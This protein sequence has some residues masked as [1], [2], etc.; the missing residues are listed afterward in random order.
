MPRSPRNAE[1]GAFLR[2]RRAERAPED[3]SL[4]ITGDDRR[5]PGL[6]RQ[7]VAELAS[8]S[9][10]YYTRIEQGRMTAS[11]PV[12]ANLAQALRLSPDEWTYMLKLAVDRPCHHTDADGEPMRVDATV[13]RLLNDLGRTPAFVIGPHTEVLAWNTL[14]TRVFLDFGQVPAP[15]RIF[16]RLLFTDPSLRALYA[17][18]AEVAHLAIDQLRMHTVHDLDDPALHALVEELSA[19]SPEFT[20]WWEARQVNIRTTGTKLLHHPVVGDLELDWSTL[21]CAAS[22]DQQVVA[23]T[24]EPGSATS[25]ALRELI[26]AP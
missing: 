21:T 11:L 15:Q 18:W 13:Q 14:A 4:S 16:V 20:A 9:M 3:V 22:P 10:D 1:L 26:T 7:E 5:V 23:W 17:D 24:A 8:I 2:Q 19:L 25:R 6:R 12:L